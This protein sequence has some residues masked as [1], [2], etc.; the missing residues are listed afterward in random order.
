M[1][2]YFFC[3]LLRVRH[4]NLYMSFDSGRSWFL[5]GEYAGSTVFVPRLGDDSGQLNSLL[6]LEDP[7]KEHAWTNCARFA[8]CNLMRI[9]F[10]TE[11]LDFLS[12]NTI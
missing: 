3:L 5:V 9:D 8:A 1:Y 7:T 11:K 2:N 6:F 12:V 4:P 10:D